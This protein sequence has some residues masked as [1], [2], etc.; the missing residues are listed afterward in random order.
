MSNE[1]EPTVESRRIYK[2]RIINVREDT[3]RLANGKLAYREIV[4]HSETICVVPIDENNNVLLVEQYRKPTGQR[5][6][7]VSAGG[8]EEGETPEQATLRELQE[9]VGVTAGKLQHLS[10]FWLTPGFCTEKMHGFIATDLRPSRLSPD[11]DEDVRA[12]P[13]P[14]EQVFEDI[15]DLKILDAKSIAMLLWVLKLRG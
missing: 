13:V 2:G 5:L 14:M 11:E 15:E 8:I 7:E 10:T 9:E 1:E 3:V 4:E 6:L 12:V